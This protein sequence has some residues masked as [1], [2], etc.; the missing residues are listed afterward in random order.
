MLEDRLRRALGLLCAAFGLVYLAPVAFAW[1]SPVAPLALRASARAWSLFFYVHFVSLAAG[2]LGLQALF[3]AKTKLFH[4]GPLIDFL[5]GV[6]AF[7][8]AETA[9]GL[10]L[11]RGAG[12]SWPALLPGLLLIAFGLRLRTGLPLFGS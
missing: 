6:A 4:G 8:L 2:G 11:R 12:P 1:L 5:I 7:M 9:S 3:A 10:A